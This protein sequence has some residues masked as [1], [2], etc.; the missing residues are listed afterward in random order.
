MYKQPESKDVKFLAWNSVE[1]QGFKNRFS[2]TTKKTKKCPK[3]FLNDPILYHR[4]IDSSQGQLLIE[5]RR[6]ISSNEY[7]SNGSIFFFRVTLVT[8][9]KYFRNLQFGF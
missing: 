4:D 9:A 6:L 5:W 3:V 8:L 7:L 1:S 2:L